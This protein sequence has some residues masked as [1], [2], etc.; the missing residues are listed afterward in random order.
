M[1]KLTGFSSLTLLVGIGS[2]LV[3]NPWKMKASSTWLNVLLGLLIHQ[4]SWKWGNTLVLTRNLG[5]SNL[6]LHF[7]DTKNQV[8][9]TK[10][11]INMNLYTQNPLNCSKFWGV[12]FTE[13]SIFPVVS[14]KTLSPTGH[15][16]CS[17]STN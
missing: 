9:L 15:F 16:N 6:L 12:T 5:F 8:L 4:L 3:V 14:R 13:F 10:I 17:K 11:V 7:L 1:S 2:F